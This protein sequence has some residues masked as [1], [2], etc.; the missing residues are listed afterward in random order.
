MLMEGTEQVLKYHTS[1]RGWTF[2]RHGSEE[3]QMFPEGP[4]LVVK[5]GDLGKWEYGNAW[6]DSETSIG[7]LG[8]ITGHEQSNHEI[9]DQVAMFLA[10]AAPILLGNVHSIETRNP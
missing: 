6:K 1:E 3:L 8:T 4:R 2:L 5:R 9:G 7:L 10:L